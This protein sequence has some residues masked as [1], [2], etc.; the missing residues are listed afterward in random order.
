MK[1]QN[2]I[3]EALA[4]GI[5]PRDEFITRMNTTAKKLGMKN[6][7]FHTP[8]GLPTRSSP[9]GVRTTENHFNTSTEVD[10]QLLVNHTFSASY[11]IWSPTQSVSQDFS[12]SQIK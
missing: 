4:S 7:I 2:T 3:A 8:S 12:D 10:L 1:S 9:R 5:T 6:T 11:P